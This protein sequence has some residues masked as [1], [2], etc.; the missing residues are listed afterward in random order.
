[1]PDLPAPDDR[2]DLQV[3]GR[4]REYHAR[5]ILSHQHAHVRFIA[6]VA[7]PQAMMTE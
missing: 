2:R 4:I 7:A 5:P 6:C 3:V 1:M